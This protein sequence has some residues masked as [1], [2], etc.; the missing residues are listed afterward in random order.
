MQNKAV[1]F[2]VLQESQKSDGTSS[3]IA[4]HT[5]TPCQLIDLNITTTAAFEKV[6][7]SA[8]PSIIPMGIKSCICKIVGKFENNMILDCVN[9]TVINTEVTNEDILN[10]TA[11]D[12]TNRLA[13]KVVD[14]LSDYP[15]LDGIWSIKSFVWD[16]SAK[17][18]G[19]YGFTAELSYY[20]SNPAEVQFYAGD[21]A[22]KA[23][24]AANFEVI[25][26]GSHK[27]SIYATK[28]HESLNDINTARFSIANSTNLI[29]KDDTV[30]IYRKNAYD[31]IAFNGYVINVI[32]NKDNTF[33]YECKE[34]GNLL[35][36]MPIIKST[37]GIFKSRIIIHNPTDPYGNLTIQ[38]FVNAM[39][40]F[41]THHPNVTYTPGSG[42]C[43]AGNLST[44]QTIPGK[45]NTYLPATVISGKS[46]GKALNDFL[47]NTC[48]FSV[49]YNRNTGAVEYG[50]IRDAITLNITSEYIMSTEKLEDENAIP[51]KPYVVEVWNADASGKGYYPKS[52]LTEG[53][54]NIMRF[55][56][57]SNNFS[58]TLDAFAERIYTD[59][60]LNTDIFRVT[61]PPGTVRFKEG[62]YFK[63]LG[64]QT[65]TYPMEYKTGND[66]N[67]LETPGD[68]VWRIT[69]VIITEN[70]TEVIVGPSYYSIF[71]IYHTSLSTIDG[72]PT[73]TETI[74]EKT[75]TFVTQG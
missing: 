8:T 35:Y 4:I 52:G 18:L 36:E 61:F 72:V 25:V 64:D 67:P 37:G 9:G 5:L 69:D 34:L 62:D 47:E 46:I 19:R 33:T 42:I 54:F 49:W 16:R 39:M 24:E 73:T 11:P 43:R 63:G 32:N 15:E 51:Y 50:F 1:Q 12:S 26:N 65:I 2:R 53:T 40:S 41:Y 45:D 56:L 30:K 48:G 14:G 70:S 31:V 74:T 57:S 22:N 13:L 68:S 60:Q 66:A 10:V 17:E 7:V 58:G 23:R 28:I 75:G 44:S 71:D 21:T 29:D 59:A 20:W 27:Y 3:W 55:K 6:E 38:D